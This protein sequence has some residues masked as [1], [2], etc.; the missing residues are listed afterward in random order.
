M[1]QVFDKNI[2]DRKLLNYDRSENFN[3]YSLQQNSHALYIKGLVQ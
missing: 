1:L 3:V 2:Y